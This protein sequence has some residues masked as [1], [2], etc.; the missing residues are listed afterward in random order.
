MSN[1]PLFAQRLARVIARTCRPSPRRRLHLERLE[2]RLAPA[3]LTVN[4]PADTANP[5]DPDL[6]LREAITIVNSPS[7]PS[8]LSNQILGQISGTLHAGAATPSPSTR[9]R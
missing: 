8:G 5:S 6:S 7:L 9:R 2:G 4:S 1:H 3:T